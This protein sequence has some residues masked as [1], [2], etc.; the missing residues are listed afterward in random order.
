MRFNSTMTRSTLLLLSLTM[1]LTGCARGPHLLDL[2]IP[3]RTIIT[4]PPLDPPPTTAIDAL[5]ADAAVHPETGQWAVKL[6]KH[7]T[8]LD[9]CSKPAP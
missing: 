9:S 1:L 6:E 7:L 4:C 8:K 5:E 3:P 2:T